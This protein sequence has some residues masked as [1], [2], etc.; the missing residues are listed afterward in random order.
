MLLSCFREKMP[1]C[2]AAGERARI[3]KCGRCKDLQASRAGKNNAPGLGGIA[4]G[5]RETLKCK[6]VFAYVRAPF[7]IFACFHCRVSNLVHKKWL[8]YRVI[9]LP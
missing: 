3:H 2:E 1:G 8:Q 9:H 5:K 7:N 6:A 4:S